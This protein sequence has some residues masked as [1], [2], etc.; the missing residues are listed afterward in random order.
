[1]MAA[2]STTRPITPQ[3]LLADI[4]RLTPTQKTGLTKLGITNTYDLLYYFPARYSTIAEVKLIRDLT[5]GENAVVYGRVILAK[6]AKGFHSK[7]PMTEATIEDG[8]GKLKAVWFHQA[9]IA[10]Q[11]EPDT[12]VK[13]SGR[14]EE[15]GGSLYIANPEFE[16]T[17]ELP[18]DAG[19]SL[20]GADAA[21]FFY[22]VYPE[23][24]GVTSR[25]LY[26][27]IQKVLTMGILDHLTDPIPGDIL[28]RYHLPSL[29]TALV[30]IH[31]PQKEKN[32]QAARKRFAFEEV[33]VIQL[34]RQKERAAFEMHRAFTISPDPDA[35]KRFIERFPF[36]PTSSQMKALESIFTDF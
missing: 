22:P 35:L 15:R 18:I 7:I 17:K 36:T 11:L 27:H 16:R 8:T 10:K 32:A 9:Y 31:A 6:T 33:F 29:K 4:F 28:E 20:F 1:T 12:M 14:I 13:L 30:W 34:A 3:T 23:T 2:K 5:A 19:H 24:K 21:A 25:F 26:H